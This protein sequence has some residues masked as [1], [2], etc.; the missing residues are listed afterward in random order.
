[1]LFDPAGNRKYLTTAERRAFIAAA[2]GLE[3]K[4]MTFCLTLAY[5]GARISEVLALTP[6]RIDKASG[7]IVIETLK[8]RR[9]CVFRAVPVPVMLTARLD[10]VHNLSRAYEKNP[11]G[12]LWPW[13]RT[14]AWAQVKRVLLD[15]GIHASRAMPKSLRHGFAAGYLEEDVPLNIVQK[16]MGHARLTTTALYGN[17]I[18]REERRL[19]QKTWK[20]LSFSDENPATAA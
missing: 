19:A 7:V 14:T 20:R 8:R 10:A 3:P 13:S 1:M 12:R 18:G 15:A 16:W 17:L 5:T 11:G 9:S 6:E 4:A 2:Q